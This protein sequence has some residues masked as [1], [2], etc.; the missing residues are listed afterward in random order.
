M[1]ERPNRVLLREHL[2]R[3]ICGSNSDAPARMVDVHVSRLRAAL[4]GP[5]DVDLIKTVRSVGYVLEV[6]EPEPWLPRSRRRV[7][8]IEET[9]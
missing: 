2:L 6:S 8:E 5:S 9:L 3:A 4:K 1:L 7:S